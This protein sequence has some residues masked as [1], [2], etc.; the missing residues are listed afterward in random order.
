MKRQRADTH[1]CIAP[2]YCG[3]QSITGWKLV[4]IGFFGNFHRRFLIKSPCRAP[5]P[6]P[7]A[8]KLQRL[9]FTCAGC[10]HQQD[11]KRGRDH[12]FPTRAQK[13]KK[14]STASPPSCTPA[15]RSHLPTRTHLGVLRVRRGTAPPPSAINNDANQLISKNSKNFN[16]F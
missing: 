3:D 11:I 7:Q 13:G 6:T 2:L 4:V 5:P 1:S 8:R 14:Y 15:P 16:Y 12:R 10:T 9:A